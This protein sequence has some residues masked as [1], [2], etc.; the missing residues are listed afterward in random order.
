MIKPFTFEN[1]PNGAKL[2]VRVD[3]KTSEGLRCAHAVVYLTTEGEFNMSP[4]QLRDL[5]DECE[6]ME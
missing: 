1:I 6:A 4:Q 3:D 5:A 2:H